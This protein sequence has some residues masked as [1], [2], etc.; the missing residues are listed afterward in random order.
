MGSVSRPRPHREGGDQMTHQPR[1]NQFDG[2]VP[3]WL[4]IVS[5]TRRL[6]RRFYWRNPMAVCC[7][8]TTSVIGAYLLCC[9]SSVLRD[10]PERRGFLSIL[11]G[12][13]PRRIATLGRAQLLSPFPHKPSALAGAGGALP[14]QRRSERD[15]DENYWADD[16]G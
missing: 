9:A 4:D 15:E 11:Q 10:T 1:R 6:S 2:S 12:V 7:G 14:R 13:A 5:A 3:A 16:A 8:T